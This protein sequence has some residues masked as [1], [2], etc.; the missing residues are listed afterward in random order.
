[1]KHKDEFEL[2]LKECLHLR[3]CVA[4]L[5]GD[6]AHIVPILA[7]WTSFRITPSTP[8]GHQ[9]VQLGGNSDPSPLSSKK[10]FCS[11]CHKPFL[12]PP[13]FLSAS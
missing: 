8:P 3:L 11:W 4:V 5:A 9:H 1:M 2:G 12:S 6:Y 10:G 7:I 13:P